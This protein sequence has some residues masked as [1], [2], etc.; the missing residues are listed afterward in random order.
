M[1]IKKKKW[2]CK[3]QEREEIEKLAIHLNISTVTAK[4]LLNRGIKEIDKAKR[5]LAPKVEDLY[6]PF[7]L[8]DMYKAVNRIKYAIENKE[9]IWIYGDYDVDGV[10]SVS[11]MIRYF[12]SIDYAVNYY[13]PDRMEEGYGVNKSAIKEIAK[14]GGDLIITVDCGITSIE[15]VDYAMHLGMDMIITDHHNCQTT[16]PKAYA[17]L[18]PKQ[19]SCQYPFDKLCGCGVAFKLIQALIP[20]EDFVIKSQ[21]YLDILAIAT[22]ADIVSLEEENRIFVKNGLKLMKNTNNLG[23]KALLEVCGLKGKKINSGHIAYMIGPRINAA[24]RV[25]SAEIAVK[26]FTTNDPKEAKELALFLDEENRNRQQ[27]EAQILD[28]ALKMIEEEP[29]Y[30]KEKVLV[31]YKEDWHHGIIGIVASK[32]IDKYYKP[33]I[34]LSIEDGI[35]KGSARSISGFDLFKSLD[36]CKEL[37]IKFGGHELAAG[38][39][40]NADN[41]E[42]F[43]KKI[44]K[45]ADELL[46]EDD[47][48]PQIFCDD[49]LSLKDINDKLIYELESLEP[50]GLGNITPK[51]LNLKLKPNEVKS[52]GV[53][54]KHLKM[55]VQEDR[56]ILGTIGF[57]LG[58]YRTHI[59]SQDTIALVFSPEFNIYNGNKKIQLNV[60]DI[61]IMRSNEISKL[62]EVEKYYKHLEFPEYDCVYGE[63]SLDI[64]PITIDNNKD[65]VILR[66]L[67][68]QKKLLF[69]VNT[70]QQANNLMKLS[71]IREKAKDI[72]VK[73]YYNETPNHCEDDEVHIVINPNIDK[74]LF[75]IYNSIIVYDMFF[76]W[77]DYYYFTKKNNNPN[78]MI[79][80]SEDDG[81]SNLEVLKSITPT[82]EDLVELYK[83]LK[84]Y[85]SMESIEFN[86][87]LH[88]IKNSEKIYVNEKLLKNA[89]EIFKEG[90]L[91]E[92]HVKDNYYSL[93]VLNAR[94][95]INI[96]GLRTFKQWKNSLLDFTIFMKQWENQIK[97]GSKNGSI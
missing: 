35:A 92:Y 23:V 77:K 72:I 4:I 62:E 89:L 96:E 75:K 69:L 84:K 73:I 14:S 63:V 49:K 71:E 60:K 79:F 48:I 85:D 65:E 36:Q 33:T 45:I 74:I 52:V 94:K 81:K 38:L 47:L 88:E 25:G 44:N 17:I 3:E 93:K 20:S 9:S 27:L 31:I 1:T 54:S 24:G 97:G 8:K 42:E 59:S 90:K 68:Q 10:A 78:T 29:R 30:Q 22:V 18:N 21:D 46:Q 86:K 83:Q 51:F 66:I 37:F 53:D 7:L 91:M 57:N 2:I 67:Q 5:F 56:I 70:I 64:I 61:K 50:F 76:S 19:I 39:S 43:R 95:K 15:E 6:D 13:I 41:I 12:S 34:I 26:L 28:E 40:L 11:L 80:Y 58:Y 16:L 87:L 82:R 55:Y 32:I